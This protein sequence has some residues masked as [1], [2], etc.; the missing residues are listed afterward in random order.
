MKSR[1]S[2]TMSPLSDLSLALVVSDWK[3]A[4]ALALGV[5]SQAKIWTKRTGFFEGTKQS[6]CLPLHEA[7]VTTAPVD[8]VKAILNAHTDAARTKETAYS[9]LPLH[10]ACRRK[11]SD[12]AVIA[13]LLT[14][15]KAAC[16]VPDD[17][18]RLPLHYA[19]SNGAHAQVIHM[20]LSACPES[21]RG[22][23]NASWTPLH[24]ACTIGPSMGV[25]T[26][27][28]HIYPEAAILRTD[29]GSTPVKCLSATTQHRAE[30]KEL[31]REATQRFDET[32]VNPL[33]KTRLLLADNHD[34]FLV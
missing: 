8:T 22:V 31:L 1:R 11:M 33:L 30:I 34:A 19:L 7:C 28:L 18:G 10:C 14:A 9:R 15:H 26:A 2:Q 3:K 4:K 16:L 6:T 27:L 20:I 17:L 21:A 25:V 23:D 5:P 12:P 13:L 24:V 29:R 32:F